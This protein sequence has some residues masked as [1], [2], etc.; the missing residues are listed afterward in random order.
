MTAETFIQWKNTKVCMDFHCP[1]GTHGHLD[2]DFAYFVKCPTC[3]TVYELATRVDVTVVEGEPPMRPRML[4][5][6]P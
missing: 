5:V 2:S 6:D 4:E 3:G 1:C